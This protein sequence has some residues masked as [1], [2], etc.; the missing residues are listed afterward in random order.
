MRLAAAGRVI[1]PYITKWDA[2]QDLRPTLMM[3]PDGIDYADELLDDRDDHGGLWQQ[4]AARDGVGRPAFGEVHPWGS[5][6]R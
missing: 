6:G 4:T 2:E 3:R 1:A 5:G